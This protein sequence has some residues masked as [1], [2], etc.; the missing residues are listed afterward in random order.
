MTNFKKSHDIADQSNDEVRKSQK[1]DANLQKNSSLY[2]QIGL[3]LCLLGTYALFEMRFESKTHEQPTLAI[4][5]DDPTFDVQNFIP[6]EVVVK[7]KIVKIEEPTILDKNPTIIDDK[8]STPETKKILT[9]AKPTSDPVDPKSLGKIEKPKDDVEK[10]FNMVNVEI[11]PIYPGCEKKANNEDRIKCMSEKLTQLIQ[12][13]FNIDLAGQLGLTGIQRIN[14]QFKINK[15]GE[16][17]DILT[18]APH[19]E[20]EKE[21]ERL[22]KR[23]PTMMPGL[24]RHK[25]VSVLYN[26]PIVFKVQD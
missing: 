15:S 5:P 4:L 10:P 12:R 21:A 24:Q 7:K 25:P 13:K 3:I 18:R 1:H 8:D 11:V 19:P 22:A 6:E 14:L 9:E 16:I 17:S 23:I 2:F 26:L 20:L